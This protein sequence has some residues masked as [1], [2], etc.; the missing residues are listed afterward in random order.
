MANP[1]EIETALGFDFGLSK[2]GVASGQFITQTASPIGILRAKEGVPNWLEVAQLLKKFKPQALII[3][4]P[5]N[6]DESENNMCIFARKFANQLHGRF[7]KKIYLVDERLSSTGVAYE[8]ADMGQNPHSKSRTRKK[9]DHLA[10][11]LILES[12]FRSHQD[13]KVVQPLIPVMTDIVSPLAG[14]T[15]QQAAG[16]LGREGAETQDQV[17]L[18]NSDDLVIGQEEKLRAHELGLLHRA[19]SVFIY[20]KNLN[21]LNNL[22][23]LLQKR[24]KN[25]YHSGG[26][27]TNTCCS[28]PRPGENI[29]KAGERRLFEEM[30]IK[31]PL[32]NIGS[33][34]YKAD[35][36]NGLVEHE[37]DH[38]LVA[39]FQPPLCPS[40]SSSGLSLPP[41]ER[42][43]PEI[44]PNP[45][46]VEEIQW[47]DLEKLDQWLL[48]KPEDFTPWFKQAYALF[49]KKIL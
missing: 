43:D 7:G 45:E 15:D 38:V 3:G 19:F 39:E 36:E 21:N 37:F 11:C 22:E 10:A 30:G 46:E 18:V 47:I 40:I 1:I 8:L 23:I 2:I 48:T 25:K 27:W 4:L 33:F 6:M 28:H 14:E 24:N 20:R 13:A 34:I 5:L 29:L 44:N 42:R 31:T 12:F 26:L 49:L 9:I 32:K 35:F 41:G 16:R 17:I